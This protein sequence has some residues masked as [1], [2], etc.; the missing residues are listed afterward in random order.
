M[1]WPLLIVAVCFALG[2]LTAE[3]VMFPVNYLLIAALTLVI[4][5][6]P[7]ARVRLFLFWP[8]LV[9]AGAANFT[10]RTAI[11]APDDL[12]RILGREPQEVTVRGTLADTPSQR[13]YDRDGTERWRTLG[14]IEVEA[15]R[16]NQDAAEWTTGYGDLLVTTPDILPDQFFRGQKVQ[17]KGVIR[18][19]RNALAPGLFDYRAYLKRQGIYYQLSVSSTNDWDL[20][21]PPGELPVS[22]RFGRWAQETLARGL[23]RD[24][25]VE[26][27]W[28]MTLGWKTALTGEV[29][30]PFMRSGTMHVFAISGL[31]I[32]LIAAILV[33]TLKLARLRRSTCAWIVI[34]LIWGYTMATGWQASAVRSTIMSSVIIFG[35]CL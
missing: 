8:A 31:H 17:I 6:I 26:L 19:P 7:F 11:I 13:V 35:W 1:R 15:I 22:A 16:L 12:R 20:L 10:V 2:I 4:L 9:L 28:A 30:E 18:E 32:A 21:S 27:L 34:P 24:R 14:Q 29:S 3:A 5:S 23:P 33:A 25:Y